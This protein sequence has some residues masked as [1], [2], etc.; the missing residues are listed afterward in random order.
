[1]RNG[2]PEG[3]AGEVEL[4]DDDENLLIPAIVMGTLEEA[5][6]VNE[7]RGQTGSMLDVGQEAVFRGHEPLRQVAAAALACE[8]VLASEH[9]PENDVARAFIGEVVRLC[10]LAQQRDTVLTIY[11]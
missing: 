4:G 8:M 2:W 9:E 5:G 1:M 6:F 10:E 11:L 3:I 7:V